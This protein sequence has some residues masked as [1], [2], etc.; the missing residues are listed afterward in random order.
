VTTLSAAGVDGRFNSSSVFG[1]NLIIVSGLS[2][3]LGSANGAGICVMSIKVK[4]EIV[5]KY[6]L[7]IAMQVPSAKDKVNVH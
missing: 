6:A 3:A 4:V 1:R 2:A 7:S 5:Q